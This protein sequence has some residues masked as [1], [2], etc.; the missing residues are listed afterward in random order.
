MGRLSAPIRSWLLPRLTA[1]R[2]DGQSRPVLA[3]PVQKKNQYRLW[4]ADGQILTMTFA[5][6][7]QARF[8][9]QKWTVNGQTAR[10][11]AAT[12]G[13][14]RELSSVGFASFENS[15]FV[16]RLDHTDS[17]DG[18]E[19]PSSITL[20]PIHVTGPGRYERLNIGHLHGLTEGEFEFQTQIGINQALPSGHITTSMF[21]QPPFA[22][23][24][25][26]ARGRSFTLKIDT[27]GAPQHTL[28]M[29]E[30]PDISQ[31]NLER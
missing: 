2:S 16:Y 6:D 9:F 22:K 19:I 5:D 11:I 29:I 12:N 28:Q 27:T 20:N 13:L 3:Q 31:R 26:K 30:F 14:D 1:L 10:V 8:T 7:Q 15:P 17:F 23:F 18:E 21:K 25:H 24:R 4:F